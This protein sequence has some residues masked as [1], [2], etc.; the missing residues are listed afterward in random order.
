MVFFNSFSNQNKHLFCFYQNNNF[1]FMFIERHKNN[2]TNY[3]IRIENSNESSLCVKNKIRY[4]HI[5]KNINN[6]KFK[7][8][9]VNFY[10][11]ITSLK[12]V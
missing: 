7:K 6:L 4:K 3:I 1:Y 12:K 2:D 5:Y 8:F 10:F 9:I 11:Y